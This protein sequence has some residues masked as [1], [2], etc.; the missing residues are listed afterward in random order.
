MVDFLSLQLC[1]LTREAYGHWNLP[2]AWWAHK[3]AHEGWVQISV[4]KGW[5][6][7]LQS[8][9]RQPK[10]F[11]TSTECQEKNELP[12]WVEH[13]PTSIQWQ[14]SG[15]ALWQVYVLQEGGP[16]RTS[17]QLSDSRLPPH[18]TEPSVSLENGPWPWFQSG[19]D[20]GILFTEPITLVPLLPQTLWVF[21]IWPEVEGQ[22]LGMLS[23][24]PGDRP[25]QLPQP[26]QCLVSHFPGKHSAPS[27][28]VKERMKSRTVCPTYWLRE[29]LEAAHGLL[30]DRQGPCFPTQILT[31]AIW[32]SPAILLRWHFWA[33]REMKKKRYK[34]PETKRAFDF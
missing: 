25:P 7:T 27:Q 11:L 29:T 28:T 4:S 34:S 10:V 30:P 31:L 18:R 3:A 21:P 26:P 12:P 19:C 33:K 23:W 9:L 20:T 13:T 17:S 24:T 16:A 14:G 2:I 1:F 5:G 8:F 22:Q 6:F 15:P 32:L